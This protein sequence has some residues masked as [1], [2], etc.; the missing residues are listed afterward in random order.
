MPKTTTLRLSEDAIKQG[1][2]L[3][4]VQGLSLSALLREMIHARFAKFEKERSEHNRP[5]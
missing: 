2:I 3:A 1:K 4:A 5:Y